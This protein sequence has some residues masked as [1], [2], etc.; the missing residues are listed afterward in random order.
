MSDHD[1]G[2]LIQE[3]DEVAAEVSSI[4]TRRVLDDVSRARARA[5][6]AGG[7]FRDYTDTDAGAQQ[8][9]SEQDQVRAE[10]Q[11]RNGRRP[12]LSQLMVTVGVVALLLRPQ[13][14]FSSRAPQLR[15][16]LLQVAELAVAWVEAI[17]GR[18]Q[19]KRMERMQRKPW[20]LRLRDWWRNRR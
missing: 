9:W 20:L 16:A 12:W 8:L 5:D 13:E 11:A 7:Y 10:A 2:A 3:W 19:E 18:E 4:P 1:E 6:E 15:G 14:A 17:D